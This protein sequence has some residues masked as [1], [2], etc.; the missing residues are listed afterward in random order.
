[1]MDAG[2]KSWSALAKW[3]AIRERMASLDR[4]TDQLRKDIADNAAI[5]AELRRQLDELERE[6]CPQ[7]VDAEP[8]GPGVVKRTV[9]VLVEGPCCGLMCHW[10]E[11]DWCHLFKR[12]LEE[13]S[14]PGPLAGRR[15]AC[16]E[17]L[18]LE[19][20]ANNEEDV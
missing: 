15:R 17:C 6:M 10:G 3:N 12:D 14:D 2:G 19:G 16:L 7:P 9:E 1:M 18:D 4:H 8:K 20:Y 5:Q 13:E 11:R